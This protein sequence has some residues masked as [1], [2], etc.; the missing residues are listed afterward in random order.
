MISLST[1]VLTVEWISFCTSVS[2]SDWARRAMWGFLHKLRTRAKTGAC[3]GGYREVSPAGYW[4]AQLPAGEMTLS[5]FGR[6][7]GDLVEE[8]EHVLPR[9]GRCLRA[10]EHAEVTARG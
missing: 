2:P 3:L 6:L 10:A 8:V 4:D 9:R 5:R 7:L 1:N